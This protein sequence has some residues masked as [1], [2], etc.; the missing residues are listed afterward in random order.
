MSNT[1][2]TNVTDRSI[3]EIAQ[4]QR[5]FFKHIA[6][7]AHWGLRIALAS[8]FI[9]HGVGKFTDLAGFAQMMNLPFAV[10]VLV[11]LAEVAGGALVLVGGVT[12]DWITRLGAAMFI[13]VM[14]GA[15]AMVHWGRWSFV[16]TEAYPMGGM[17]FQVTLLLVALA[18]V[19]KGNRG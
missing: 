18:F 17:E 10:A 4:G 3:G 6:A 5:G 11:A 16:P 2:A 1:I 7:H 19:L 8:V 12:R 15:I 13:P 14:I 9:F